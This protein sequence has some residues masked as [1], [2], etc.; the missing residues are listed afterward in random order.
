MAIVDVVVP[1]VITVIA[2]A[3]PCASI[4]FCRLRLVGFGWSVPPG[5]ARFRPGPVRPVRPFPQEELMAYMICLN[6]SFSAIADQ[7]GDS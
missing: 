5:S 2:T 6:V 4:L 7:I 3:F 1:V